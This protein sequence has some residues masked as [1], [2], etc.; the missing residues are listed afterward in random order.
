MNEW[1][2]SPPPI[3][4]RP[5]GEADLYRQLYQERQAA[6][7]NGG[8]ATHGRAYRDECIEEI[9]IALY[10]F[11]PKLQPWDGDPFSWYEDRWEVNNVRE[12]YRLRAAVIRELVLKQL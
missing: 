2:Q 3:E 4:E 8:P 9:A 12:T 5:R 6:K 1:I 7:H 10:N 11:D